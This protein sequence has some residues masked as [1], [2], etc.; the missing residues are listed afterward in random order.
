MA[1]ILPLTRRAGGSSQPNK[2]R[3]T[4][5]SSIRQ[6]PDSDESM[7]SSDTDVSDEDGIERAQQAI[8][9]SYQSRPVPHYPTFVFQD[10]RSYEKLRQKL[11]DEGNSDGLLRYFDE[12]LRT[13][14]NA[15][16]GELTLRIMNSSMHEVVQG[17]LVDA[18]TKELDRV[19]ANHSLRAIREKIQSGS[20]ARLRD[21]STEHSIHKSPDG[22]FF[23]DDI[24][25]APFVIEIAYSEEEHKLLAKIKDYF[26]HLYP[27]STILAVD[28]EYAPLE[29]RQAPSHTHRATVCLWTEERTGDTISIIPQQKAVF[30]ENGQALLGQLVIPFKFLLPPEKRTGAQAQD[31]ELRFSYESLAQMVSHGE[32]RQRVEDRKSP[33][34]LVSRKRLR[35]IV[36][37]LNGNIKTDE[38]IEPEA[39]QQRANS[40][41]SEL[42]ETKGRTRLRAKLASRLNSPPSLRT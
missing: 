28:I 7:I 32:K 6:G 24:Q 15:R 9:D 4:L 10:E 29:M 14:W 27:V 36:F 25:G 31:Q 26:I 22:Q 19:A 8:Q 1:S 23:Y 34:M 20:H 21:A 17:R 13:D 5:S 3:D 33:P 16:T 12:S 40:L 41:S 35:C 2:R 18:I 42:T 30:R 11:R 37:D 39:K 38:M